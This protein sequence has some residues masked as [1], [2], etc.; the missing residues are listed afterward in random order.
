MP[1]RG[2]WDTLP[3]L[4]YSRRSMQVPVGE[5]GAGPYALAAGPDGALWVTLV[6]S[7]EI[8][9]VTVDG[10]VDVHSLG[11]PE[12][13]PSLITAARDGALWFTRAGDD[14]IGR[15]T[16]AGEATAFALPAGSQP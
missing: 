9:R 12:S 4:D 14:K 7:G 6:H 1:G 2:C 5:A 13:R 10:Q 8:A 3:I 15:I 11:A 16:T